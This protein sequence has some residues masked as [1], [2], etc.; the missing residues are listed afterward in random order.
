MI[1]SDVMIRAMNGDRSA[2]STV[3]NTGGTRLV[4]F[5]YGMLA[6][7]EAA[8]DI[9]QDVFVKL[10]TSRATYR[11]SG[12]PEAFLLKVVRNACIDRMRSVRRRTEISIDDAREADL[13]VGPYRHPLSDAVDG[14]VR[15]LPE[16]QR[17]VF[18][19]SEYE[20]LTYQEIA[21]ILGCPHGT[22]ASR[23]SAAMESLRR[24]LQP[25]RE[26]EL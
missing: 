19:L 2:F 1:D 4:R 21:D 18:V 6:D 3:V 12:S 22:V 10:W 25:C 9:V 13:S 11:P 7:R 23:K 5:A 15:Q 14:A 16:A 8:R 20:G 26:G 24:L 17:T